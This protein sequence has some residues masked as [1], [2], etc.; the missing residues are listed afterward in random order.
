MRIIIEDN[1]GNDLCSFYVFDPAG[2]ELVLVSLERCNLSDTDTDEDG[3]KIYR[4][5]LEDAKL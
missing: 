4:I 1:K 5:Q 2:L 3:E